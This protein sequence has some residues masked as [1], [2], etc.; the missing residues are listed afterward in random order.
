MPILNAKEIYKYLHNENIRD[1]INEGHGIAFGEI[2]SEKKLCLKRK[3][4]R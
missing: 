3:N 4:N 1:A 2:R